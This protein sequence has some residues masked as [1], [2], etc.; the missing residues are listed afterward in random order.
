MIKYHL[1]AIENYDLIIIEIYH[2]ITVKDY[3]LIVVEV[4]LDYSHL[5]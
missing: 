5:L 3:Q 1:L 4:Y 2:L